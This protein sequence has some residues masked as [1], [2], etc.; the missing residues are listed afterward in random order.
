MT[1]GVTVVAVAPVNDMVKMTDVAI[2]IVV[3][4]ASAAVKAVNNVMIITNALAANVEY[5]ETLVCWNCSH[6]QK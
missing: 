5:H 6:P 3:M 4:L 2:V 1:V